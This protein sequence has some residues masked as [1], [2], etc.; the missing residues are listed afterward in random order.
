MW[1]DAMRI[2]T[3]TLA[4]VALGAGSAIAIMWPWGSML[5]LEAASVLGVVLGFAMTVIAD[6]LVPRIRW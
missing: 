6:H 2:L 5:S 4:V 1:S 3:R